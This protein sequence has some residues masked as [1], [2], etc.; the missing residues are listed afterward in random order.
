MCCVC[1]FSLHRE[2]LDMMLGDKPLIFQGGSATP[3]RTPYRPMLAL[4]LGA[5]ET[6]VCAMGTCEPSCTGRPARLFFMFEARSPQE[7][8]GHVAALEPSR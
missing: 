3:A 6:C 4:T 5:L 2:S 7:T 1:V 8:T